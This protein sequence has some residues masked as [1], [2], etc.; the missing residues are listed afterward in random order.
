MITAS[1]NHYLDNGVKI[2]NEDGSMLNEEQEN[3]IEKYVNNEL[4]I[5]HDKINKSSKSNIY[6]GMDTRK[7]CNLIFS[8]ISYGIKIINQNINIINLGKVTTQHHFMTKYKY[9]NQLKYVKFYNDALNYLLL[10]N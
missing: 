6:I 7:D 3:F 2:V 1:H 9:K 8:E 4:T 5:D 10:K